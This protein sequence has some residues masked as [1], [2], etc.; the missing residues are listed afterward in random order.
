M[1]DTYEQLVERYLTCNG[2][3]FV[4]PQFN[5]AYDPIQKD[6]GSEPD[7]VVL[8]YD[9]GKNV[10]VEVTEAANLTGLLDKVGDPN[11]RW[12]KP[13]VRSLN[14]RGIVSETCPIRFLGVVREELLEHVSS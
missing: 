3:A 2:L 1:S 10:V 9:A 11:C 8:D 5:V 14:E 4:C 7:F 6:G 13:I 12:F